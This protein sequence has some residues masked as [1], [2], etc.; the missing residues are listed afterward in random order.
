M[1]EC[2]HYCPRLQVLDCGGGA[3]GGGGVG[4]HYEVDVLAVQ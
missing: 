3:D 2:H 4:V 1:L